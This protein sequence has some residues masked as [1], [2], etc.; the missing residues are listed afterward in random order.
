MISILDHTMDQG[1]INK[2][3]KPLLIYMDNCPKKWL[4]ISKGTTEDFKRFQMKNSKS[5]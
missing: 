1:E 4:Q 2:H 3:K 5:Q